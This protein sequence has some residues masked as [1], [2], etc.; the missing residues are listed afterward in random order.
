[1]AITFDEKKKKKERENSNLVAVN[2]H[3]RRPSSITTSKISHVTKN[4]DWFLAYDQS[5]Q[6]TNVKPVARFF[7]KVI[8]TY[9]GNTNSTS[10]I[11]NDNDS[12]N[13]KII[14]NDHVK[15]YNYDIESDVVAWHR[16]N[17]PTFAVSMMIM[18]THAIYLCWEYISL[19]D[20]SVL[21]NEKCVS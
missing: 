10:Y 19:Q 15:D 5:D 21:R 8:Q 13:E 18:K 16:D 7:F 11:D 9:N 2:L 17:C 3:D 6:L 12:N 14:S 20:F 1:M 4:R